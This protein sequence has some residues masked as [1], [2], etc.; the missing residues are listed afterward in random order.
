M[1]KAD[2]YSS[3]LM[4][5]AQIHAFTKSFELELRLKATECLP[6]FILWSDMVGLDPDPAMER[7]DSD[8][9]TL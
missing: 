7:R 6:R 9:M 5:V 4:G 8:T 2:E 1:Y 3:R